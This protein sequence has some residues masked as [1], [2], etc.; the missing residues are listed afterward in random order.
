MRNDGQKVCQKGHFWQISVEI[1]S[2]WLTEQRNLLH[3]LGIVI[4]SSFLFSFQNSENCH[5]WRH[6][7]FGSVSVQGRQ[8]THR[9]AHFVSREAKKVSIF[10]WTVKSESPLLSGSFRVYHLARPKGSF[11]RFSPICHFLPESSPRAKKHARNTEK[12]NFSAVFALFRLL[13]A[14]EKRDYYPGKISLTKGNYPSR[15]GS[16]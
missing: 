6:R 15:S 8:S 14:I 13:G 3:L 9:I 11:C 12:I 7:L 10:V 1:I 2:N 5:K 4:L 16:A